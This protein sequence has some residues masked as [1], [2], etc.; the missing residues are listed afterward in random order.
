M[1]ADLFYSIWPY[2]IFRS[3]FFR[4]GLAFLTAYLI[5]VVAMPPL[6]RLF[7]RKGFTSD[8]RPQS[9][10]QRPYAGGKPIMGGGVLVA[11][12]LV[13]VLL[14]VN[15]N[16]FIVAL[17]VI[18]LCFAVI[19][20]WDDVAKIR[21]RG[22]VERGEA[23][24]AS[25]SDKAEGVSERGRLLAEI[26]VATVVVAGLYR[27]VDIDGHLVIPFIPL[28]WWYPYL[29]RHIFIPFMVLIIVAGA[30]SVNITDGLDSLAT[31]P[32]LTSTLFIAGVA[33][34]GGEADLAQ[35][36]RVPALSPDLKELSVM[37]AAILSAGLA[38]LR[39]N[40]PPA[41]IVMGDLGALAL[42]STFSAMFIFLKVELF[43]PLVGGLLVLS[44]LSTIIQRVFFKLMLAWKGRE[45]AERL[46]FFYRAP[47]H[48]HLQSLWTYVEGERRVK[49]VWVAFL[50]RL[51]IGAPEAED[52]LAHPEEVNSR[53]VWRMHMISIWLFVV[54][55]VVYFKVR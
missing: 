11:A 7:R 13:S 18:M 1:L 31:V 10:A 45:A 14:W 43:L 24:K 22:R 12:V 2:Q 23:E 4:A 30:N 15:W 41:M 54:T 46:R 51:G 20:A 19:G 26:V 5:T 8:F 42:G 29:P 48:H 35:R 33:Y 50:E 52:Q 17:L 6:I 38:F 16:Q 37:C 28:E 49:S 53:V 39:Y 47:Y 36:F 3:I 27:F 32:I 34:V 44:T 55:T 40:A 25:Y 21:Q 9:P